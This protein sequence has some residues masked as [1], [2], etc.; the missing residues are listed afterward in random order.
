MLFDH[1]YI[2]V[3]TYA[4][5]HVS[6]NNDIVFLDVSLDRTPHKYRPRNVVF[7]LLT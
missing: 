2:I 4:L 1:S 5:P 6:Y 3:I 7:S